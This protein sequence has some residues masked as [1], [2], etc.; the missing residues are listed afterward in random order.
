MSPLLIIPQEESAKES[1]YISQDSKESSSVHDG[2]S[3]KAPSGRA[4]LGVS[5]NS[6][7]N[8]SIES[9]SDISAHSLACPTDEESRA[10]YPLSNG[11]AR[12]RSRS[13]GS[14]RC[15]RHRLNDFW[16]RNKGLI[17]VILAQLFGALMSVTT[18][19]LETDGKHGPGMHPFQV[20]AATLRMAIGRSL[21]LMSRSCS[22]A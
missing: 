4:H 3:V 18:R 1:S 10:G 11:G 8:S 21:K 16:A 17:L 22:P 20:I 6:S 12:L 15:R 13:P 7:F 5:L 2:H 14:E 9:L 19:L